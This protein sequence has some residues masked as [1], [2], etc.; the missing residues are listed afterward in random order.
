M[1]HACM[2]VWIKILKKKSSE[3][4]TN[5]ISTIPIETKL[6]A[7]HLIP[8]TIFFFHNILEHI[9]INHVFEISNMLWRGEDIYTII[10]F[11]K[12]FKMIHIMKIARKIVFNWYFKIIIKW[13]KVSFSFIKSNFNF[14]HGEI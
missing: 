6:Y 9:L 1:N 8:E 4:K 10:T 7:L 11:N 14:P 3:F 12:Q 2:N 5:K 13:L